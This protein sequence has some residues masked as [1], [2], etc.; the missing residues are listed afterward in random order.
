MRILALFPLLLLLWPAT[1]HAQRVAPNPFAAASQPRLAHV[2]APVLAAEPTCRER[3]ISSIASN[4][5]GASVA[6][7]FAGWL[8]GRFAAIDGGST[9]SLG[10]KGLVLGAFVGA[11]FG[12]WWAAHSPECENG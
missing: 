1:V 6:F 8:L 11:G 10:T 4:A 2:G 5:F 7:G 3:M 12:A 9:R